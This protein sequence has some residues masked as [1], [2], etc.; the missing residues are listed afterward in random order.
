MEQVRHNP[1]LGLGAGLLADAGGGITRVARLSARALADAG[2]NL[3][4][5]SLLDR[6][7]VAL[8]GAAVR[9]C[10][11]SKLL[12]TA[13]TLVTAISTS[14]MLYDALGVSRAHPNWL[15]DRKFAVWIHGVE[16]WHGLTPAYAS[17]LRR[18]D[19]VL[20]NSQYT[21][22]RHED[23]HG[24]LAT[25]R[26]CWLATEEREPPPRLADFAGPPTALIVGRIDA[27]EGFKGHAEL[28]A[29]WPSVIA[30]VPDARLVIAGG[31]SGL[32]GIRADAAAT[33]VGH[34]I[35]VLGFV[36]NARLSELFRQAHV[37]AMPSRQEGFGIAYAE[38]MRY[39]VPC[40]A[41]R[42][43]GGQEVNADWETGYNVD[44]DRKGELAHRLVELLGQR[45]TAARMGG[46]AHRRW[47]KHF[48]YDSFAARF[49]ACWLD[50]MTGVA[51]AALT[52]A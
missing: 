51:P 23:M 29:A 17:A 15:P 7:A 43:D 1:S 20:C 5:L 39:G 27:T 49:Q 12:F 25:A 26:V 30:E 18:A 35:D 38:A 36:E 48:G 44:L 31:G 3:T 11:G 21:L 34:A 47:Q 8:T 2:W 42:Q 46:A 40:I 6:E 16:V 52:T 32:A 41:S 4:V 45:Q 19:L 50:F 14:A 22:R 24:K 10:R 37:F 13:R 33:G 28:L 9:G